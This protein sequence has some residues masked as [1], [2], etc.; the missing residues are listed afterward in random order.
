MLFRSHDL[1]KLFSVR[2]GGLMRLEPD[3]GQYELLVGGD[4]LD[5]E[6]AALVE[7]VVFVIMGIAP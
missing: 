1:G 3:P 7:S 4:E 5:L 2:L 6:R